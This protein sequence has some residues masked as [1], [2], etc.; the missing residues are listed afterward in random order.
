VRSGDLLALRMGTNEVI[1]CKIETWNWKPSSPFFF[2]R[3][4]LGMYVL[5]SSPLRDEQDGRRSG[6]M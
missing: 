4:S 1:I 5:E 6:K 3:F 2:C